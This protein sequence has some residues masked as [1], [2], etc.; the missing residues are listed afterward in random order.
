MD[1]LV[2][3]LWFALALA[4]IVLDQRAWRAAPAASVA[5]LEGEP[6]AR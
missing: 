2:G 3:T 6:V 1:R 4:V 5:E